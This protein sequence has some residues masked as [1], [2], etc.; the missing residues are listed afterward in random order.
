MHLDWTHLNVALKHI[1]AI[2]QKSICSTLS[3]LCQEN[4]FCI[5]TKIKY[6]DDC[7]SISSVWVK[8]YIFDRGL[9]KQSVTFRSHG[10]FS[11]I[12]WR[13]RGCATWV[14]LTSH[15]L[16]GKP[17]NYI[18]CTKKKKYQGLQNNIHKSTEWR[19]DGAFDTKDTL[20]FIFEGGV[21]RVGGTSSIWKRIKCDSLNRFPYIH[22]ALT[23][24]NA[25]FFS[26][27][28]SFFT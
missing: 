24:K 2:I 16:K 25:C 13:I 7:L 11:H 23:A 12:F 21:G 14:W 3:V 4:N 1:S 15:R 5:N 17:K 19:K 27:L 26:F 8:T 22:N 20:K 9:S 18:Y 28:E 6:T 10:L